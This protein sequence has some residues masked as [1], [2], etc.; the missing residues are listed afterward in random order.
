MPGFSIEQILRAASAD[1]PKR[2][3][4]IGPF[5]KRINFAAQQNRAVN[6]V[7]ALVK[8][9][10]IEKDRPLAVVGGGLAGL[11]A[12]TILHLLGFEVH[13]FERAPMVLARQRATSHRVLHPTV[14]AWPFETD[15]E[16]TTEL[17]IFDWSAGVCDEVLKELAAEWQLVAGE[18]LETGRRLNLRTTVLDFELRDE[19]V[20]LITDKVVDQKRF[21]TVIFAIGFDDERPL[22]N[23]PKQSY[24]RDEGAE[25][26]RN[27]EGDIRFVVS[28][29]GDG[30]LIDVL[31]LSYTDFGKGAL[32]LQIVTR[33]AGSDVEKSV[34][35][36]EDAF[37]GDNVEQDLWSAYLRAAKRLPA[38]AAA[39][40]EQSRLDIPALVTL[41]GEDAT[42]TARAAAPIHKL[43]TAYTWQSG[44]VRYLPGTLTVANDGKITVLTS[45]KQQLELGT[46]LHPPLVRHGAENALKGLLRNYPGV[47]D[48]LIKRQEVLA[49]DFVRPIDPVWLAN[50]VKLP[51][52]FVAQDFGSRTFWTERHKKLN[53]LSRIW[54]HVLN[55]SI[56]DTGY[57]VEI[58]GAGWTPPRLFGVAARPRAPALAKRK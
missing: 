57:E 1:N 48:K 11:T 9:N 12:A 20:I 27:L 52:G 55:V 17:P 43:M 5:A 19:E 22:A 7:Y 28:G 13:L 29:T 35:D 21:G 42:L 45:K 40:L 14:N 38:D 10:K 15:L 36:A 24:W 51:A 32:P 25:E 2:V 47:L 18:Q 56:G 30:G 3:Y 4:F 58:E 33:L 34:K 44:T 31:R 37:T 16:P 53:G 23:A 54:P 39:L 8:K 50:E 46:G 49:D 6:L 41:V 26:V